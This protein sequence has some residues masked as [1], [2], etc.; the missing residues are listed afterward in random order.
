MSEQEV[1]TCLKE[2]LKYHMN[3]YNTISEQCKKDCVERIKGFLPKL[4]KEQAETLF[5][6]KILF[7]RT[8]DSKHFDNIR[9]QKY[10]NGIVVEIK[11]GKTLMIDNSDIGIFT[12]ELQTVGGVM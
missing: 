8:E 9:Y 11:Q 4:S 10:I 1:I 3:R 5:E 2:H 7:E 12:K 6:D